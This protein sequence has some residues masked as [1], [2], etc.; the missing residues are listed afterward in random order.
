MSSHQS[1]ACKGKKKA[2]LIAVR[3]VE[4]IDV[5]LP[6]THY[7]AEELK[8]LLIDQYDYVEDDIVTLLD[9]NKLHEHDRGL[10]NTTSSRGSNGLYKMSESTTGWYSTTQVMAH[11]LPAA[12]VLKLIGKMNVTFILLVTPVYINLT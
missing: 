2:L 8:K 10:P 11:R 1:A 6:Q 3:K 4:G 9:D 7:D 5:P 12:M